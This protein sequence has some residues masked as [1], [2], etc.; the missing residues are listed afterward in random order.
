[1]P[2]TELRAKKIAPDQRSASQRLAKPVLRRAK[3]SQGA[4]P[5]RGAAGREGSQ[6]GAR[7]EV[8]LTGG[9]KLTERVSAV[10]GTPR[11]PMSRAEVVY[12]ARDLTAPVLGREAADRLIETVLAIEAVA[13][14]RTIA[15]AASARLTTAAARLPAAMHAAGAAPAGCSSKKAPPSATLLPPALSIA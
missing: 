14:V 8:E 10:R 9:T 3:P 13:D 2:L 11:N 1:M 15:P 7:G 5:Y 12:K 4:G 6:R